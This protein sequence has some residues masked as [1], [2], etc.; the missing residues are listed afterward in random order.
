MLS[1]GCAAGAPLE[2]VNAACGQAAVFLAGLQIS[3][4]DGCS[5]LAA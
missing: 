1:L 4:T 3:V 2:G 5:L